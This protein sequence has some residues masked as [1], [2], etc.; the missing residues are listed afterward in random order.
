MTDGRSLF[1]GGS[2]RQNESRGESVLERTPVVLSRGAPLKTDFMTMT[3]LWAVRLAIPV[4]WFMAIAGILHFKAMLDTGVAGLEGLTGTE[5]AIGAL[6]AKFR[7][8]IVALLGGALA[9][10]GLLAVMHKHLRGDSGDR[11]Q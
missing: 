1:R 11:G 8:A 7:F 6:R 3:G 5:E 9:S 4:A 2:I 10:H